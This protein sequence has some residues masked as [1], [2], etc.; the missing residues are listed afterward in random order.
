L[1]KNFHVRF[2]GHIN[3]H[4]RPENFPK[5]VFVDYTL[6]DFSD[7]QLKKFV[8]DRMTDFIRQQGMVVHK[9]PFEILDETLLTFDKKIY[10]PFTMIAWMD[11]QVSF[12]QDQLPQEME[13]GKATLPD[14]SQR[15]IQ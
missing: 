8:G 11:L 14:G 6:E 10:V 4:I 12:I 2:V 7:E 3:E 9:K 5:E 1:S 13:D 15:P